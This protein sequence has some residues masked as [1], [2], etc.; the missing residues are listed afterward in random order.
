MTVREHLFTLTSVELAE[1]LE[2]IRQM[3]MGCSELDDSRCMAAYLDSEYRNNDY[4]D[5]E[6]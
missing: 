5:Y 3:A 6:E 4:S 2:R 1:E